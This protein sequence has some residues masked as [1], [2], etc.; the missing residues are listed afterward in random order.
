MPRGK[1]GNRTRNR[2]LA[3]AFASENVTGR[4]TRPGHILEARQGS[5][6]GGGP[7]P[8]SPPPRITSAAPSALSS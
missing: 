4:E 1:D 8:T 5:E 3:A 2:S 7:M 6:G